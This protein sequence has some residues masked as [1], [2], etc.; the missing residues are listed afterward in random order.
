MFKQA[1]VLAIHAGANMSYGTFEE[2]KSQLEAQTKELEQVV[3]PLVNTDKKVFIV[4]P[5][6]GQLDK[7]STGGQHWAMVRSRMK[8]V[9]KETKANWVSLENIPWVHAED[10]EDDEVHY[11]KSGTLKVMTAL[12]AKVKEIANVDILEGME[13]QERP[14]EGIYRGHYK[15]GCYK[16]T[17]I[18]DKGTLCP[19]SNINGSPA[20]SSTNSISSWCLWY[21]G[22]CSSF[23][24]RKCR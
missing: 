9:S 5:V 20:N 17:R 16:C 10:V 23:C 8:K 13:M 2:S 1:D 18:H 22:R 12:A 14:Y 11:T 6:P 15:F 24:H 4:D 21:D 19:Q 7:E 3:K